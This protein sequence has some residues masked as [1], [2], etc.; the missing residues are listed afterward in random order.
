MVRIEGDLGDF[1]NL[2]QMVC[3]AVLRGYELL[4]TPPDEMTK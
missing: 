3:E 2:V 4:H 1:K